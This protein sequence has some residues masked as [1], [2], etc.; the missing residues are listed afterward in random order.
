MLQLTIKATKRTDDGKITE[1][2]VNVNRNTKL[3]FN[4]VNGDNNYISA[5]YDKY[6]K[7]VSLLPVI[8]STMSNVVSSTKSLIT[9]GITDAYKL[10]KGK[11]VRAIAGV[12]CAFNTFYL[13]AEGALKVYTPGD[14][15]LAL[16]R[17]HASKFALNKL[18][19]LQNKYIIKLEY[20]KI[21]ALQ[22]CLYQTLCKLL[23]KLLQVTEPYGLIRN[24]IGTQTKYN[25]TAFKKSFDPMV[26]GTPNA[27]YI[28]PYFKNSS[29]A[30]ASLSVDV[31]IKGL[32]K[33]P[34][35][36]GIY[37]HQADKYT[38]ISDKYVATYT[39][40]KQ[41]VDITDPNNCDWR[42]PS[43]S[44]PFGKITV[45]SVS[46]DPQSAFSAVFSIAKNINVNGFTSIGSLSG[47]GGKPAEFEVVITFNVLYYEDNK[48]L[49][50]THTVTTYMAQILK[51]RSLVGTNINGE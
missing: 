13:F 33:N 3:C 4:I 50:Y 11:Y 15:E 18:F 35:Y 20:Y 12:S 51:G 45:A 24:Y 37:L 39:I 23:Y 44:V 30:P 14:Y 46:I 17:T 2:T 38:T 29:C 49:T 41:G 28:R 40:V 10:R 19:E 1:R 27:I 9:K 36:Y 34:Q 31:T 7:E 32:P 47:S 8:F 26:I 16:V 21:Y 22:M 25:L 43:S 48:Q 6:N 42:S 5:L